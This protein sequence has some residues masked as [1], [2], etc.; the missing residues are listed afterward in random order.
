[1]Y[2]TFNN[3]LLKAN[4]ITEQ[5]ITQNQSLGTYKYYIGG[6][7]NHML[8]KQ[9]FKQRT[10]WNQSEK[11]S[12]EECNFV[13]T[14]WLKDRHIKALPPYGNQEANCQDPMEQESNSGIKI[15]NKIENNECLS[16]KKNLFFNMRDLYKAE[17]RDLFSVMPI[18]FVINDGL[19]DLEFDRFEAVFKG[20][21]EQIKKYP[22]L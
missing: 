7:N 11:E 14:Q 20:I 2:T 13:W 1:M 6:G 9:V 21:E 10:W 18:T 12:F 19:N 15:Y 16:D 22:Q 5:E 17:G 4:G 8:V 3:N